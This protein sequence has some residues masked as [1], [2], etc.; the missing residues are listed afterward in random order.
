MND[1][2]IKTWFPFILW[3][4]F[5]LLPSCLKSTTCPVWSN[6]GAPVKYRGALFFSPTE[7]EYPADTYDIICSILFH[8]KEAR[9]IYK[10]SNAV[11]EGFSF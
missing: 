1:K 10:R 4:A 3:A 2:Q 9:I 5:Q 11:K 8:I 6:L 7:I